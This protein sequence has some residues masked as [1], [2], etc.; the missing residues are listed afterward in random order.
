MKIWT[1]VKEVELV[2]VTYLSDSNKRLHTFCNGELTKHDFVNVCFIAAEQ[3][4][5]IQAKLLGAAIELVAGGIAH[6]M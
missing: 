4:S 3:V 1:R 2:A 5:D 6:H